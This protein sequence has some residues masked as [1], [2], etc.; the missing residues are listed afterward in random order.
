MN[1][2]GFSTGALAYS[3]FNKALNLVKYSPVNAIELSALRR[4][5]LEPLTKSVSDL[6]LSSF[7]YI[8]VHAPGKYDKDDEVNVVKLLDIFANNAWPIVLHPDA[9]YNYKLWDHFGSLLLIENMD[10]RKSIGRTCLE[11]D[12]IFNYLPNARFCFDIAHARQIDKSMTIAKQILNKYS[13]LITQVHISDVDEN[14]RH[15]EISNSAIDDF[16]LVTDFIPSTSAIIIE[17]IME[18]VDVEAELNSA[19]LSFPNRFWH[20]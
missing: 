14:C 10:K 8:S 13:N 5:E 11:L 1:L 20:N 17:T 4:Y 2:I 18:S 7:N 15:N 16:K 12:E 6:D 19:K 3:D 9:I